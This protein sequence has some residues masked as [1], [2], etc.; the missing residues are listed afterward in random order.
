MR[1]ARASPR[2]LL[3]S[4][5]SRSRHMR[6]SSSSC[7]ATRRCAIRV[8]ARRAAISGGAAAA[9][10]GRDPDGAGAAASPW[11]RHRRRRGGGR[12]GR[13]P[14]RSAQ[15][16]SPPL[17]AS[18]PGE[19]LVSEGIVHLARRMDGM[20]YVDRG[21]MRLKGLENPVQVMQAS[22]FDLPAAGQVQRRTGWTQ[23]RIAAFAV[24]LIALIA[25]VVALAATRLNNHSDVVLAANAVG[26][27]DA[28]G[29]VSAQ[30]ILPG[31]RP[32]GI[33]A[34]SGPC[35]R[36]MRDETPSLR[37]SR[38]AAGS[39]IRCPTSVASRPASQSA[40]AVRPLTNLAA[41]AAP[42]PAG[43]RAGRARGGDGRRG[44]GV[45]ATSRR[46]P[47]STSTWI[48]RRPPRCFEAGLALEL[49]PARRHAPGGAAAERPHRAARRCPDYRTARFIHDFTC[50][51]FAFGAGRGDGGIAL[52]DPLAMGVALDPRS[53]PSSRSG[54]MS[55]RGQA[56]PRPLRGRPPRAPRTGA[57]APQLPVA[58]DRRRRR[59]SRAV[60]GAPVPRIA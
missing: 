29:R 58:M 43:A 33:G 23:P 16:V 53:S 5:A 39:S 51:G 32:G 12:G 20:T 28:S 46:R 7:V 36:R 60:P 24:V 45:P 37:S 57:A 59:A 9:L 14:R 35:G 8:A 42:T 55:S 49:D 3:R 44:H 17:R 22:W 31:G 11:D 41:A 38:T 13:L 34:G 1:P 21:R 27:L 47:S 48:R 25:A 40:A 52:H 30:V 4:C 50:H 6:E 15:S 54:S 18:G 2:A 26:V 19:V 10:C 56:D